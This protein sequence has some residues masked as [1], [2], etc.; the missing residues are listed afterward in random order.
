MD[1]EIYVLLQLNR[2]PQWTAGPTKHGLYMISLNGVQAQSDGVKDTLFELASYAAGVDIVFSFSLL[3]NKHQ[4]SKRRSS[5]I[6]L[7]L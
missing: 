7:L 1:E 2:L 6:I 5:N 3:L 4:K